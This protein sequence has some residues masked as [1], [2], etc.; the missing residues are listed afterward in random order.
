[1]GKRRMPGEGSIFRTTRKL[2]D[3]RIRDRWQ[4]Q[5][6]VGGRTD[7][8]LVTRTCRTRVE[9]AAALRELKA[10]A[11]IPSRKI[12]VGDYLERWVR[13]A[14]NIRPT[15]RHGYEAVITYHLRPTIGHVQLR[16]LSPAYVEN[17]LAKLAPTMSPKSLRNVHIV[18]RRALG[19]ALRAGLVA[20][21]VASREYV[22]AP[23]VPVAEPRALSGEEVDRFLET[24]RGDRLEALFVTEMGTGLRLGE[25]CGLSNEDIDLT[26]G[27]L[28]APAVGFEPTTK[29]LTAARSTTELRRS[30]SIA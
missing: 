4:A 30:E 25:L 2:A 29:R 19:Q 5:L 18:L 17:A 28:L 22:D 15:T 9:A 14:R 12:S 21:N 11:A 27:R 26:A 3:G 23:R 16:E 7:R 24:C 20:R 13:D 10:A 1:M 6:S 8:R